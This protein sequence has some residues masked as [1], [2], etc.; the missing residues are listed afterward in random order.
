MYGKRLAAIRNYRNMTQRELAVTL[1]ISGTAIARYE[2]DVLKPDEA[3]I[4]AL[5][6]AL[7]CTVAELTADIHAPLPLV[8]FRGI[9]PN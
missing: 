8:R 9:V 5:A 7:H 6:R 1:K 2:A 3:M 4:K